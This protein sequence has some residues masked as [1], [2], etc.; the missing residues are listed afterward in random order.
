MK[1]IFSHNNHAPTVSY[2][3]VDE[4]SKERSKVMRFWSATAALIIICFLLGWDLGLHIANRQLKT[5]IQEYKMKV[6]YIEE[7]Y[8]KKYFKN[9]NQWKCNKEVLSNGF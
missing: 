6:E 9:F 1:K 3:T 7:T 5:E 2:V 8:G 4:P